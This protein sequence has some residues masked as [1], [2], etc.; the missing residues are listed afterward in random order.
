[1]IIRLDKKSHDRGFQDG[2]EKKT[3]LSHQELILAGFDELSYL[4][5]ILDGKTR[6]TTTGSRSGA[7]YEQT[8][9]EREGSVCA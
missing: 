8:G 9:W 5:G 7:K 1:M 6:K 4:S 2:R 3:S